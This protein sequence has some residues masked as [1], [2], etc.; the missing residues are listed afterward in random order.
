MT[1]S[2]VARSDDGLWHVHYDGK[3]RL[4]VRLGQNPAFIMMGDEGREFL[5][6]L[7]EVFDET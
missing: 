7:K 5:D 1:E 2:K 4:Y 6:G 3:G